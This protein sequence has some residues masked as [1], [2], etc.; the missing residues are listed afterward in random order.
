MNDNKVFDFVLYKAENDAKLFLDDMYENDYKRINAIMDPY[1]INS[2]T[3]Y[4]MLL[5]E[6]IDAYGKLTQ[7]SEANKTLLA[8]GVKIKDE[9]SV[10]VDTKDQMDTIKHYLDIAE[11]LDDCMTDTAKIMADL[12]ARIQSSF[13]LITH[14]ELESVFKIPEINSRAERMYLDIK[15][16][17]NYDKIF[18]YLVTSI[19][20]LAIDYNTLPSE[21]FEQVAN[22]NVNMLK[23]YLG[24]QH[25][26][27]YETYVL[28]D[29]IV[30]RSLD[31]I[32]RLERF[33]ASIFNDDINP[34]PNEHCQ[35]IADKKSI[36]KLVSDFDA[37]DKK[38][39]SDLGPH[40][41]RKFSNNI[42]GIIN[43]CDYLSGD[44][45]LIDS[46]ELENDILYN[47]ITTAPHQLETFVKFLIDEKIKLPLASDRI[48]FYLTDL[49]SKF[50]NRTISKAFIEEH[51]SGLPNI[52]QFRNDNNI[53]SEMISF[54]K[55]KKDCK[56][57]SSNTNQNKKDKKQKLAKQ[58]PVD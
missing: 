12:H 19:V 36:K 11:Q 46:N 9:A 29:K 18:N 41:G 57:K 31:N 7:L 14:M 20:D 54:V 42:L 53:T 39:F 27:L 6:K 17:Q 58:T 37:N 49:A 38:V 26:S 4:L 28:Y 51:G 2:I 25:V 10:D 34:Q 5:N 13:A 40:D 1:K 3:L 45:V 23:S 50:D 48:E 33:M 56:E 32:A 8:S 24:E 35:L 21:M 55:S 43:R 16:S 22:D 44:E 47:I 52:D 15:Y 30:L